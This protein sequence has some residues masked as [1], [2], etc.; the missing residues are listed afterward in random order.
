MFADRFRG[1]V[2]VDNDKRRRDDRISLCIAF[3]AYSWLA[4]VLGEP[5]RTAAIG[6]LLV[7]GICMFCFAVYYCVSVPQSAAVRSGK[8]LLY[9]P[10]SRRFALVSVLAMMLVVA[11]P[12]VEAA[13]LDRR[14]RALTRSTPLS[15]GAA[16]QITHDLEIA[17]LWNV[18]LP[19]QTLVLVR[20]TIKKSAL[21]APQVALAR[22][23]NALVNYDRQDPR[24]AAT[25]KD[26]PPS[27]LAEFRQGLMHFSASMTQENPAELTLS[28]LPL[29]HAIEQANGNPRFQARALEARAMSYALLGNRD[30][31]LADLRAAEDLGSLSI[32]EMTIIEGSVLSTQTNPDDLRRAI[33]LLTL[34]LQLNVDQRLDPPLYRL[35]AHS[36]RCGAYFRLGEYQNAV[37]DAQEIVASRTGNRVLL[38]IT[39]RVMILSYLGLHN[40][41]EAVKSAIEFRTRVGGPRA[42]RWFEMVQQYPQDPQFVWNVLYEEVVGQS[43]AIATP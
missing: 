14:L 25:L 35:M 9:R 12:Q 26:V 20:D 4:L 32:P 42:E 30:A 19:P 24:V 39:Y 36:A 3:F 33:S 37:A 40:Y 43:S 8:G 5:A 29:T 22:P 16:E 18:P 38:D 10:V 11:M 15:P 34:A 2:F 7:L 23:A 27:A 31:A 41:Q 21:Q 6:G 17:K 13:A 1:Y 28:L